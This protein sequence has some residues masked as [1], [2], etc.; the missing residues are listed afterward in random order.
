MQDGINK[1]MTLN[2]KVA[3]TYVV[4]QVW[5]KKKSWPIFW[6]Q[7]P[8][9]LPWKPCCPSRFPMRSQFD[10]EVIQLGSN[11]G[12]FSALY[13]QKLGLNKGERT[14]YP[15]LIKNCLKWQSQ[16]KCWITTT[17]LGLWAKVVISG[18]HCGWFVISKD[19]FTTAENEIIG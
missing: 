1:V 3:N 12:P 11:P 16:I 17:D 2:L 10:L 5:R 13:T 4:N 8:F 14:I 7:S 15:P 9:L 19:F 6:R 18:C